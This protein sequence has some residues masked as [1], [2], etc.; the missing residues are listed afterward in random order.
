MF[1]IGRKN[2]ICNQL[3][4]YIHYVYC[5]NYFLFNR[6]TLIYEVPKKRKNINLLKK[7][8][9]ESKFWC[10]KIGDKI[11]WKFIKHF[12]VGPSLLF[13]AAVFCCMENFSVWIFTFYQSC[14]ILQ[15][16]KITYVNNKITPVFPAIPASKRGVQ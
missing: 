16:V 13:V 3:T 14:L 12:S 7:R 5:H 10:T 9:R 4:L 6:S 11:T 1:K 2:K 15:S 8:H